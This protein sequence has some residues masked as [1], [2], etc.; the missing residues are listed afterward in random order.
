MVDLLDGPQS[1]DSKTFPS[2]LPSHCLFAPLS[3]RCPQ[4]ISLSFDP[5]FFFKLY[6]YNLNFYELFFVLLIDD[7]QSP[8]SN[9]MATALC[10]VDLGYKRQC[11]YFLPL[12][13]FISSMLLLSDC[14]HLCLSHRGSPQ[15]LN[16]FWFSKSAGTR[17]LRASS[18]HLWVQC[19]EESFAFGGWFG[20]PMSLK[21]SCCQDL[22]AGQIPQR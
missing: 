6:S 8:C 14:F 2:F 21:E 13:A 12:P 11:F 4:L 9:L 16:E 5:L 1:S 22:E 17:R 19:A 3:E 18:E 7:R 10:L 15:I 20:Q